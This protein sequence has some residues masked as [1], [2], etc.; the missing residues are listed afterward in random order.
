MAYSPAAPVETPYSATKLKYNNAAG[1]LYEVVRRLRNGKH[2]VEMM[3][4]WWKALALESRFGYG[5]TPEHRLILFQYLHRLA[6]QLDEV[7]QEAKFAFPGDEE[8]YIQHFSEFRS[9]LAPEQTNINWS[10]YAGR[11]TA[12]VT[13]DL[14]H[15]A[16]DLPKEDAVEVDALTA[17][18]N[19]AE[20]LKKAIQ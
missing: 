20:E 18:Y 1:R 13:S 12:G 16:K 11:L 2:D 8:L 6:R 15:C 19:P 4:V 3:Q 17:I 7:E 5:S 10:L 14:G 9:V